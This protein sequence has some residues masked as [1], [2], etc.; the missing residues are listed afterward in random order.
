VHAP[1][2]V[3]AC[4]EGRGAVH[5]DADSTVICHGARHLSKRLS[6]AH[7]M[8]VADATKLRSLMGPKGVRTTGQVGANRYSAELPDVCSTWSPPRSE[9]GANLPGAGDGSASPL[10]MSSKAGLSNAASDTAE[11]MNTAT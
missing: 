4:R 1:Q 6:Q 2:P 10:R 3:C 8:R 7:A 11:K 5:D 9:L